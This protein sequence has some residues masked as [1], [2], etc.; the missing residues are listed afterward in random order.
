MGDERA[1]DAASARDALEAE[2]FDLSGLDHPQEALVVEAGTQFTPDLDSYSRIVVPFSGGK[3]SACALL[4]LL[5]RGVPR[6]KIELHH[7]LVDG[8]GPVFMDWP[9]TGDY[10]KAVARA[11][12]VP[13]T[14]SYRDGGFLR[15]MLR[16]ESATAGVWV[17][18]DEGGMRYLASNGPLGTRRKFPQVTAN[19]AQRYCSGSLKIDVFARYMCNSPKF[20]NARTLVITGERAEE[21]TARARYRVFEPHRCD[22]RSSKRVPRHVDHWR[23]VHGHTEQRVWATLRRHGLQPHPAYMLGWGRLSCRNC[24]FGSDSQW[25]TSRHIAPGPFGEIARL[26][27]EFKVT[28][29]R[30]LTVEERA[31]R[32]SLYDVDPRWVEVANSTTFNE[33]VFVKDW[34]MPRGAFGESCGPT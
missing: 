32:G 2:G 22:T 4:D 12:G 11:I 21:S 18:D 20:L 25:A 30:K 14:F 9:V 3:D 33:P 6:E 8:Q 19:L 10:C 26:E 28:I 34:I 23:S 1:D 7:H 16:E 5:D 24:I 29:H 31:D 17:P 15:E 27:R 13:I